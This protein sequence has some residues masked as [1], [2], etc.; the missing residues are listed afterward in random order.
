MSKIQKCHNSDNLIKTK[1]QYIR[2]S[3]SYKMLS[4]DYCN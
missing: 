3:N 2:I 1:I 4:L